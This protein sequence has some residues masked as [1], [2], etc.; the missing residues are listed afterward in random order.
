MKSISG[1]AVTVETAYSVTPNAESAWVLD[2]SDLAIQL[3]RVKRLMVN[4]DNTV[5]INGLPYNPN[6]FPRVD[7]GAVIEQARQRCAAARTGDAGKYHSLQLVP[8]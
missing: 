8:C 4:S 3:F 1:R 7:D 5:T 2:Q 6:K